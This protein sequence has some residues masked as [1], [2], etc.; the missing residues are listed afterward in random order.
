MD[1]KQILLKLRYPPF[2]GVKKNVMTWLVNNATFTQSKLIKMISYMVL[3]FS[4]YFMR[5]YIIDF[6]KGGIAGVRSHKWVYLHNCIFDRK[7][8]I[9]RIF[10]FLKL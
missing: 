2:T 8:K 9:V 6:V 5:N 7:R 4:I 10:Y 1:R 3:L